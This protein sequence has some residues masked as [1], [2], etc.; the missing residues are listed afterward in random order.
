[1]TSIK[2]LA[3]SLL[4]FC[5]INLNESIGQE[6]DEVKLY[7]FDAGFGIGEGVSS[8][9]NFLLNI[10]GTL[11]KD[12]TMFTIKHS[13]MTE[14]SDNYVPRERLWDLGFLYGKCGQIRIGMI[15]IT[16]GLSVVGGVKRLISDNTKVELNLNNRNTIFTLGIPI[17]AQLVLKSY[18]SIGLGLKA[19]MNINPEV[20]FGGVTLNI[21]FGRF[22]EY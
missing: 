20:P 5:F 16:A 17:E 9:N 8:K 4:I 1:M 11:L 6:T 15:S 2:K 22:S 14:V 21:Y 13:N 7:W 19:F 12:G 10:S 3:L 18:N